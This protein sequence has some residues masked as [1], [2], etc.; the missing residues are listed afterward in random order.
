MRILETTSDHT[1]EL[2]HAIRTATSADEKSA[3]VRRA[4]KE[5]FYGPVRGS[6]GDSFAVGLALA[7]LIRA[8]PERLAPVYDGVAK[9]AMRHGY[10]EDA[11]DVFRI[12]EGL[13][14]S[15]KRQKTIAHLVETVAARARPAASATRRAGTPGQKRARGSRP[16]GK[17][18]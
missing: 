13:A 2:V 11:I 15:P 7:N 16:A 4:A 18:R 8:K 17:A 12:A 14:T 10:H 6:P 9:I 1:R 3:V 5:G